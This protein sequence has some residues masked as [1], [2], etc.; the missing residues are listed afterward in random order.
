[1]FK[2]ACSVG[3]AVVAA[4]CFAAAAS[5]GAAV[6]I[7]GLNWDAN[8][9]AFVGKNGL[10]VAY[11]CP[12]N[13]TLGTIYGTGVYTDDSKVC[14]AAV[15]AGLITLATGG[16]VTIK[17]L[18]GRPSYLA[19]T[20]H[21]VTSNAY[22]SWSASYSF[23]VTPKAPTGPILDGGRTWSATAAAG[24]DREP[25]PVQLSSERQARPGPW[26]DRL[27][28]QLVGLLGGRA[29]GTDQ[30]NAGRE[31]G[32]LDAGRT[33]LL[34]RY[35]QERRHESGVR[36]VEEQLHLHEAVVRVDRLLPPQSAFVRR[37]LRG[38]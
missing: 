2:R 35:G 13:G 3:F 9:T 31:R 37:A 8:A 30:R 36:A 38:K 25:L 26:L 16:T 32:H 22:G 19:S 1:M 4:V 11:K 6:P 5:A 28:L 10:L 29:R 7:G 20:R 33:I 24:Q 14:S 27:R 34:P 21:G 17:I 12:P 18:P 23:V 15:H